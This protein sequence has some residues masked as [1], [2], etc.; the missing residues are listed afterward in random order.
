MLSTRVSVAMRHR[1]SLVACRAA[2][3]V[4]ATTFNEVKF[5]KEDVEKVMME[6]PDYNFYE[7]KE[8]VPNPYQGTTLDR[9]I[10]LD[11]PAP[12]LVAPKFEFSK[13][14]NGIK[15]ASVDKQGLTA[16]LGLYVHAGS[17]FE[18]SANLGAAHMAALMGFRSTAHLSHLRTVKTL[19]QMGADQSAS[20]K[21]GRE[22]ILYQVDVQREMLPYVVPLM[23]GN[24]IFP[25]MLPWEVKSAQGDVKT[26]KEALMSNPDSMVSELLH[27][28]AYCNNTLGRS[29]LMSERSMGYFTPE[30]VRG[31][32]LDH[33]APER[34][35]FVGVNVQHAELTKWVMRSFADYNAIPM[36]KR[37]DT[38]ATYTGGD[39]RMEGKS[40][41]CH[42]ALG[43][44]SC[45]FGHAELAPVALIQELLGGGAAAT[46]TIGSGVT[47][48]LST[49]V[50]KQSP[51]VESCMAFNTSYADSG[52]F[53]VY[54][55]GQAEKVWQIP[56]EKYVASLE[57]RADALSFM[58]TTKT[59]PESSE[60]TGTASGTNDTLPERATL[61]SAGSVG[62]PDFC[63]RPC[64]LWAYGECPK[65]ATCDFCHCTHTERA[66]AKFDKFQRETLHALSECVPFWKDRM[67]AKE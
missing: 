1:A 11:P 21:S 17:R 15:I 58:P 38:K 35:V 66:K 65:G 8:P 57:E 19:E 9:S 43:L 12:A 16:R 41:Y 46:S 34:M 20:A 7:F 45:A 23:V 25:R 54:G 5:V 51:F 44:Q 27:K 59:P 2:A 30:T 67:R 49:Q 64:V 37:E 33:F 39:M 31:Y 56:T 36:K 14:E 42:L 10:L 18:T 29:P 60:S 13:L 55:V 22:E 28:A 61:P 32:L 4:P 62:H 48:R 3:Q 24:V 47:S 63:R 52:L 50:V 53:G 40:P 6:L 26:D